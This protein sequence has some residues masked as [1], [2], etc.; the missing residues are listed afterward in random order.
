MELRGGG[1]RGYRHSYRIQNSKVR[2]LT[3]TAAQGKNPTE[4]C[5]VLCTCAKCLHS[6]AVGVKLHETN[7]CRVYAW[8][9]LLTYPVMQIF[10]NLDKNK[11]VQHSLLVPG[12]PNERGKVCKT[13]GGN[14]RVVRKPLKLAFFLPVSVLGSG[15]AKESIGKSLGIVSGTGD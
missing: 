1:G 2:N 5:S 4:A 8:V 9:L 10:H 6:Q 14:T 7:G 12:I 3:D 13:T 11:N 15:E